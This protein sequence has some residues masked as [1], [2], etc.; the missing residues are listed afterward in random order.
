MYIYVYIY[1]HRVLLGP[2]LQGGP[3]EPVL[4]GRGAFRDLSFR[5][6]RFFELPT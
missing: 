1:I 6:F 3:C 2:P 4:R 5:F